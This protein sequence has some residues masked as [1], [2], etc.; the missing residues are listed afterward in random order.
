MIV[1]DREKLTIPC[2]E[3]TIEEC[4]SLDVF[5]KLSSE[6]A[7][8]PVPGVGL[9]ANQIGLDVRACVVKLELGLFVNMVNPKIEATHFPTVSE[10]EGCLSFPGVRLSTDRYMQ[11][12]CSWLDFD[13]GESR[14]AIFYG[15]EAFILQHECDHL[16]GVTL[17]DRASKPA[18][19]VG[20]NDLC[21]CGSGK[22]HKKCCLK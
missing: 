15:M 9:S 13:S 19:K 6:L 11:V 16:D 1:Q 5:S 21:P 10:N 2:R 7:E 20:R 12:T 8:S 18:Y 14:R 17:F 22:K 4:K 3:T